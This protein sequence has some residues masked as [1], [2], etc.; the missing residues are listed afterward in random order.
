MNALYAIFMSVGLD[1]ESFVLQTRTVKSPVKEISLGGSMS[2]TCSRRDD[3]VDSG[4]TVSEI[5]LV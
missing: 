1:S 3:M 2:R 4:G 5:F